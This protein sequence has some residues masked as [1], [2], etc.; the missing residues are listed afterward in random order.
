VGETDT[1]VVRG[2]TGGGEQRLTLMSDDEQ[3]Q[4]T[5]INGMPWA[6]LASTFAQTAPAASVYSA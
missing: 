2:T 6:G 1:K 4:V 5:V 3:Q